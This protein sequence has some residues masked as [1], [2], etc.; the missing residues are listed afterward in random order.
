MERVPCERSK[1]QRQ[2]LLLGNANV[3]ATDVQ[4]LDTFCISSKA[5]V[6]CLACQPTTAS[7]RLRLQNPRAHPWMF[8]M[9]FE[10]GLRMHWRE[11]DSRSKLLSLSHKSP[12]SWKVA[13]DAK[14]RRNERMARQTEAKEAKCGVVGANAF[15]RHPTSQSEK[16]SKN[17]KDNQNLD[18]IK[19]VNKMKFENQK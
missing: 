11:L 6:T 7:L 14:E 1:L 17:K 18:Q 2:S 3:A 10:Q 9:A 15:L 16:S 8:V 13:V 4:S 19:S 5:L 12:K